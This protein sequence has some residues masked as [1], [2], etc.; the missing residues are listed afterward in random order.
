MPGPAQEGYD[1]AKPHCH[2]EGNFCYEGCATHADCAD[3]SRS[4]YRAD[5][6][7]C[8]PVTRD[9]VATAPPDGGT[10]GAPPD[11]AD[12]G[13]DGPAG[14]TWPDV[15]A[16]VTKLEN[17]KPCQAASWCKSGFCADKVCCDT[18][19]AGTCQAC[20]L[21]GTKGTCTFIQKSA[22]PQAECPGDAL[23][24]DGSCDGAGSC[25]YDKAGTTCKTSCAA[26]QLTTSTCDAT[27]A[28]TPGAPTSCAP[29]V[30]DAAGS[31]CLKGCKTHTDC[32]TGSACDRA[33]AHAAAQA[34]L[35]TCIA[36]AKVVVVGASEEVADA[37][38]KVSAAK[39]YVAIPP[40]GAGVYTKALVLNGTT[41]AG[42]TVHLVGTGSAG[43][44]VILK[45]GPSTRRPSPWMTV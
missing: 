20:D 43:K 5:R 3:S 37:L 16:P 9:C 42:K 12:A 21:A 17:G 27:H 34:G 41:V 7:Y 24:G 25:S 1:P 22:G 18:A 13:P 44:P 30:C 31:A 28:C 38:S 2:G 23:C 45:P 4:W 32:V 8:D 33:G 39:P 11:A 26:G 10:D 19:C 36:P 29:T 35:G 14:D 15:D 40:R 6:P